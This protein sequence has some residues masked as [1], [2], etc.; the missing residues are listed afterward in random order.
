MLI[1]KD[2]KIL[3]G[4]TG[5]IASGK[6]FATSFFNPSYFDK[7]DTDKISEQILLSNLQIRKILLDLFGNNILDN[8]NRLDKRKLSAL[9]FGNQSIMN[10]LE[11]IIHPL[12]FI[13]I[14]KI[15]KDS[16]KRFA[17]LE[18][19]IIFEKELEKIFNKT[20]TVFAPF[21]IR[22]KRLMKR[23]KIDYKEAE[24][25]ILFQMDEYKK[26]LISDFVV[27]NS[28]DRTWLERQIKNIES[29]ILT[30]YK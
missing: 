26:I 17:I 23:A 21:E 24:K 10:Q 5:N 8:E 4:I 30:L 28:K 20:I 12:V 27:D 25:R 18:S 6:S 7:I 22:I 15:L 11:R 16:S 9:A 3:I 13:E 29:K 1:N 14:E 19:A 2:S